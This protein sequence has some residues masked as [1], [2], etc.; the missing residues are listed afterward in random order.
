MEPFKTMTVDLQG[1]VGLCGC[2]GWLPTKVGNIFQQS[3]DE[4]LGSDLSQDIRASIGRSSYE[5]CNNIT[6]GVISTDQLIRIEDLGEQDRHAV[7]HPET[8]TLP[9]EIYLSGDATCNLTCPSCRTRIF[10]ITDNQIDEQLRL[11]QILKNNLFSNNSDQPIVLHVST[12]GEVFASPL[13]LKFLSSIEP[14]KFPNLKLWLQSNGLLAP[15]FWTKLGAMADRVENITVTVDAAQGPTYEKLR[16]GGKW[17]D[18]LDSLEWI[19]NKKIENGMSL[20]V[21]MVVQQDNIDQLLEFYELGQKYLAKQIDYVRITNWGT[22]SKD[23]FKTIDVFDI[24]HPNREYA[25]SK[26]EQ[27]KQLPDVWIAGGL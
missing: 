21:R 19:K 7:T 27:I 4:I 3:V 24:N 6:C 12:S 10:K 25:L 5:Y 1:N 17:E 8:W 16:R 22:Y 14:E 2:E 26:I 18:L 9:R 20:H 13:L 15:R 23:E 11:G